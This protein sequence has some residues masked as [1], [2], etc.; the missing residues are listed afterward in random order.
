[1]TAM[2]LR[3]Q[4]AAAEAD[5]QRIAVEAADAYRLWYDL[6][7]QK[8]TKAI[9]VRELQRRIQQEEV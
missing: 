2:T 1:V 5:L 7:H 9:D 6:D 3:D 4:L 8:G